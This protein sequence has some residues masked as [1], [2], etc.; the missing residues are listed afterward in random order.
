MIGP[1][2]AVILT[3]AVAPDTCARWLS[4]IDEAYVRADA[5]PAGA[6]VPESSS[7][8]L[9]AVDG[10]AVDEVWSAL[11]PE[12]HRHCADALGDRVVIDADQCWVRRQYAPV[13][14]PARHHPHSWH[15]DGALGFDF[16]AHGVAPI[17]SD[18]LLQMVTIWIALTPCGDDAPGLEFDESTRTDVLLSPSELRDEAVNARRR[19]STRFSPVLR[20][21][22]A[23]VFGGGALHRTN[24][25]PSMTSTRT[26]IELRCF[27]ADGIPDR[28]HAD[29]FVDAALSP[30]RS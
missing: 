20:A 23:L 28:L 9:V 8:R 1:P 15:Q 19:P 29:R 26:S 5:A 11:R 25:T 17:P 14:A 30:R 13:T 24:A 4:A 27:P 12:A 6:F 18:A 16:V 22:D 21:G 10:L 2:P 7:F 3:T